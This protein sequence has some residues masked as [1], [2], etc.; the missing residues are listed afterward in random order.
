MLDKVTGTEP[1]VVVGSSLGGWI[2]LHLALLRPQRVKAGHSPTPTDAL[3]SCC[4]VTP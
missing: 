2:G 1:Q 4:S 3:P